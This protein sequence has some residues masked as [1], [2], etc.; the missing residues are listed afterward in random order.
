MSPIK[1][2]DV[3]P[4]SR[5]YRYFSKAESNPF[6]HEARRFERANA[7]WLM[8]LSLLAYEQDRQFIERE[9]I[10]VGLDRDPVY[11]GFDL[12]FL[13]TQAIVVSD[14]KFVAVVFRGSEIRGEDRVLNIVA[15]WTTDALVFLV[16]IGPGAFAHAGFTV[17]LNWV[18]PIVEK[19]I[20]GASGRTVWFA[21]HSLGAACAT[22]AAYRYS[23]GGRA[24]QGV[25][26]FGSPR[27]GDGGF[28]ERFTPR[29]FRVVH[30]RDLVTGVP[31]IGPDDGLIYRHVGRP[32]YLASDGSIGLV[33]P[34]SFPSV[35]EYR[36]DSGGREP[37]RPSNAIL[38]HA[39]V[40]YAERLWAALPA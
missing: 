22:L 30:G 8:D 20:A 25:Y 19:A 37:A 32:R 21:G 4:P 10:R 39:P 34:W 31:G 36:A 16:P 2:R 12:P 18:W 17:A 28:Q 9:L 6:R 15:D 38:D 23:R 14:M 27:V 7:A 3:W 11:I 26:T 29:A 40:L 1:P 13:S 24:V 33:P 5:S 35:D